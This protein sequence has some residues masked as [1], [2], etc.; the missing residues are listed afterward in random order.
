MKIITKTPELLAEIGELLVSA[1]LE[2][3]GLDNRALQLFVCRD[4]VGKVA[5]VAGIEAYGKACLFRSL[6]VREDQ[7]SKGLGRSLIHEALA[8]ARNSGSPDVY[9]L[10]E[11][12]GE[13][14]RCYG[15]RDIARAGVP[16]DVLTSPFFN[17]ICPCGC[18][19]MYRSLEREAE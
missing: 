14:M 16:E 10:T 13:T 4:E 15:F 5:G 18:N 8:Y 7:R 2:P 12:I 11:T 1:E 19:L 6:A 17:G 3:I 9:L